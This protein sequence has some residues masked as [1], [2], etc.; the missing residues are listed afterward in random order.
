MW[1][2]PTFYRCLILWY[3]FGLQAIM[4]NGRQDTLKDRTITFLN[5]HKV[6]L[7]TKFVLLFF[8]LGVFVF[9]V[10]LALVIYFLDHSEATYGCYRHGGYLVMEIE[11]GLAVG[12]A[13]FNMWLLWN[14]EDA[15]LIKAELGALFFLGTPFFLVWAVSAVLRWTGLLLSMFWHSVLEVVFILCSLYI[16]LVGSYV[17]TRAF[18]RYQRL[19]TEPSGGPEKQIETI[20]SHPLLQRDFELFCQ[21]TWSVENL[22]F[23]L[24]VRRYKMLPPENLLDEA[25]KMHADYIEDG[26]VLQINLVMGDREAINERISEGKAGSDLFKEAEHHV[27][28]L[29]RFS[30]IPLWT[31]SA[32]YKEL[33]KKLEVENFQELSEMELGA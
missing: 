4:V 29:L 15:Y 5:R 19:R 2:Y 33:M 8:Y 26:S 11:G 17:Y 9:F 12:L 10:S 24:A 6:L 14:T 18:H 22:L 1:V 32:G 31:S 23:Y 16:P 25:R 28:H 13:G 30:V 20:F 21:K 7:S 3:K 27:I